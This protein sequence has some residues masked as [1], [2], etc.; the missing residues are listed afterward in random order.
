MENGDTIIL[1]MRIITLIA[2]CISLYE[3]LKLRKYYIDEA[4]RN[5]EELKKSV[6][7]EK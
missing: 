3:G 2:C 1:V 5:I 4:E 6:N 7:K